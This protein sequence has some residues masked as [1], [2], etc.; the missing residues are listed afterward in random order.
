MSTEDPHPAD[1]A[2]LDESLALLVHELRA[3]LTVLVGYLGILRRNLT[4]SD[5]DAII[6]T[7]ERAAERM[8][9]ML[10]G[11]MQGQGVWAAPDP[12][13]FAPVSLRE[14]ANEVSVDFRATALQDIVVHANDD[15]FVMGDRALLERLLANLV[16]NAVKYSPEESVVTVTVEAEGDTVRLTVTDEGPGVPAEDRERIFERFARLDRDEDVPGLGIGLSI[17]ADVTAAHGGRIRAEA[18]PPRGTAFIVELPA[19]TP[20]APSSIDEALG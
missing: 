15:G 18:N 3:P 2:Q 14:L 1:S 12:S 7:M 13:D 5:R 11:V 6:A 20:P 17:A 9:D 10:E 8:D 16:G 19:G 4:P